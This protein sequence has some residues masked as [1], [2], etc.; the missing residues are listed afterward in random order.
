MIF[1]NFQIYKVN[2]NDFQCLHNGKYI[3]IVS[4]EHYIYSEQYFMLGNYDI[5]YKVVVNDDI[6]K[7]GKKVNKNDLV[8]SHEIYGFCL[9]SIFANSL[10]YI[11][12][13]KTKKK[14]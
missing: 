10:T 12:N 8:L 6:L 4:Q 3:M 2:V 13:S 9:N 14:S 7:S 1:K 11:Y 5:Y